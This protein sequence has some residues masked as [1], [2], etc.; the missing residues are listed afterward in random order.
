M[1]DRKQRV[2]WLTLA[3]ILA[4]LGVAVAIFLNP[5]LIDH[6]AFFPRDP[7]SFQALTCLFAHVNLVHLLGNLVF[8]AAVGPIVEFAK[9]PLRFLMV[10]LAAGLVGVIGFWI[11]ANAARTQVPLVGASGAISGCVA[12]CAVRF[13]R[14][15]VPI[16]VNIAVPV[17]TL[18]A[19]WLLLQIGGAIIKIGDVGSAD[20]GFW[21]HLAG[22]LAG[23]VMS[24]LL[25]ANTDAKVEFGHQVL[26][27]MNDRGPSAALAAAN[28]H[29]KSHPHDLKAWWQKVDAEIDLD[30]LD[31]AAESLKTL[32]QTHPQ[33][34]QSKIL[35]TLSKINRL[36]VIPPMDRLKSADVL[37][38]DDPALAEILYRSVADKPDDPRR[39]EALLALVELIQVRKPEESKLLAQTLVTQ[40]EL[41]PAA[42][43]ARAKGLN[44]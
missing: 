32:F 15:R 6:V 37:V 7:N 40:Y 24:A 39:P 44:Q 21:P 18:A 11:Y 8:L 29:L 17:W 22:F 43:S 9:G 38:A 34:E 36:D 25:G 20:P 1:S 19:I 2:P 41:H 4:N 14:T 23:L 13:S 27:R 35:E 30:E 12:F 10:Y 28:L 16:F 33:T 31:D 5:D 26:D 42:E 3:L